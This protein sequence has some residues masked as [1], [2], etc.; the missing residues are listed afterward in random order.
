MY[1]SSSSSFI[2]GRAILDRVAHGNVILARFS[3]F[4]KHPRHPPRLRQA[5]GTS[6][7]HLRTGTKLVCTCQVTP[8]VSFHYE[9][10]TTQ[11]RSPNL[12][13]SQSA[14]VNSHRKNKFLFATYSGNSDQY[15][16]HT[17]TRELLLIQ[18]H[19]FAGLE[20]R[21]AKAGFGS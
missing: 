15:V 21:L 3:C 2:I 20:P 17:G 13:L 12:P 8:L 4:R 16:S 1:V 11:G 9:R 10:F 6:L 14:Y 5:A 7:L 18:D 19:V